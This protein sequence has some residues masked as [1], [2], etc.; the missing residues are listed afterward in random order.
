MGDRLKRIRRRDGNRSLS[1]SDEDVKRTGCSDGFR[2]L[3]AVRCLGDRF[4]GDLYFVGCEACG[5]QNVRG[6]NPLRIGRPARE[7]GELR[8]FRL[9]RRLEPKGIDRG[10]HGLHQRRQFRVQIYFY[11]QRV[12]FFSPRLFDLAGFCKDRV[13]H[14]SPIDA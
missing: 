10:A 14:R 5:R 1:A 6:Q 9:E 4:L 11:F 2:E 7:D 8:S 3:F 13:G 12:F